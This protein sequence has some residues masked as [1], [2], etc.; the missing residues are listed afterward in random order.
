MLSSYLPFIVLSVVKNQCNYT[1]T[2][3]S[4]HYRIN[5]AIVFVLMKYGNMLKMSQLLIS[6]NQL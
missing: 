1:I 4:E 5:S 6:S 3:G 2:A